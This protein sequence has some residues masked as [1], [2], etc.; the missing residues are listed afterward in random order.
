[1]ITVYKLT[2]TGKYANGQ[3]AVVDKGTFD[4]GAWKYAWHFD[5]TTGYP[6][7]TYRLNGKTKHER[8]HEFVLGKPPRGLVTDHVDGNK[9]NNTAENLRFV[10]HSANVRNVFKLR[11]DNKTGYKG[12]T[13]S[14]HA[15][16][17]RAYHYDYDLKKQVHL[18]YFETA[19]EA[20]EEV[21]KSLNGLLKGLK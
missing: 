12:V 1:M 18:G 16:R 15:Q 14:K 13:Y 21:I 4:K 19:T 17:W 2:L 11:K 7:R 5:R 3:E 10:S 8:L 20:N 9:L 6:T